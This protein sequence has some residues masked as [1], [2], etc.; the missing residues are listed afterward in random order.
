VAALADE[1]L[2]MQR[3][4]ISSFRTYVPLVFSLFFLPESLK[5][6]MAFLAVAPLHP[7]RSPRPNFGPPLCRRN[8]VDR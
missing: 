7:Q 5:N 2:R 6:S 8:D 3:G 4:R 1:E